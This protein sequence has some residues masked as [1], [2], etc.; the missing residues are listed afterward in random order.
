MR[1]LLLTLVLVAGLGGTSGPAHGADATAPLTEPTEPP[2][3]GTIFL[4]GD[5]ITA[6]DPTALRKIG[7]T[8]RGRREM[9]DRRTDEFVT[10]RAYLFRARYR[11]GRVTEVQVNP[12]FRRVK[13]ATRQARKYAEVVG[14]LPRVL[15]RDV[16]AIWIHR[17]QELYG[18]GNR[19]ILIHTGQTR[20]YVD[21]G[22]LEETLVH[23]AAHT[24]LDED[25]AASAG[26]LQA[27]AE[28]PTFIST[29]A[30]D[31]PTSEDIAESFLPYLA[32]R[33]RPER[34]DPDVVRTI[35]ETIPARLAYFDAQDFDYRP[36]AP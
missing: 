1:S 33:F 31:N 5:I 4:D 30:R 22:I 29:Y 9:F 17:G 25:H 27:Q 12:E 14:Q 34:M 16:D 8:G 10:V 36:F 35:E 20:L 6:D 3:S 13:A 26:W 32:V 28:D 19:S 24:S 23:E 11:G 2:Y 15:L 7:Y 21:E 18:G